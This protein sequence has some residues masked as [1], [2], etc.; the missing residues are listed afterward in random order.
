MTET[1]KENFGLQRVFFDKIHSFSLTTK[2]KQRQMSNNNNKMQLTHYH[3]SVDNS[4]NLLYYTLV[5]HFI[6]TC[7]CKNTM[8]FRRPRCPIKLQF[9][10]F[11]SNAFKAAF[12][13]F[14]SN[15]GQTM[16]NKTVKLQDVPG[17]TNSPN[18]YKCIIKV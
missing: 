5:I 1:I 17:D 7:K 14:N 12:V 13:M 4:N 16:K 9:P 11:Q 8:L 10:Y 6:Y 3:Y 2:N 18:I 15:C